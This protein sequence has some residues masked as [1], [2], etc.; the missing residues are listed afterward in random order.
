MINDTLIGELKK[1]YLSGKYSNEEIGNKY[2]VSKYAI[3]R[4]A[5]RFAWKNSLRPGRRAFYEFQNKGKLPGNSIEG[6]DLYKLND[7]ALKD[8]KKYLSNK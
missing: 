6:Y 3:Y 5:K 7:N 8:F 4:L 1:L 2:N